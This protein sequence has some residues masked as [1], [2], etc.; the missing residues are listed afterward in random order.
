MPDFF[1]SFQVFSKLGKQISD[2]EGKHF[3]QDCQN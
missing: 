2:F 3:W 1:I